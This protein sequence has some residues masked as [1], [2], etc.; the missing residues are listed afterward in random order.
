M[1]YIS[2]TQAAEKWGLSPRRVQKLC[3]QGRIHGAG[4]VGRAWLIPRD[5]EKPADA[6]RNPKTAG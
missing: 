1:E 6:R 2:A 4:R 3:A 5:A